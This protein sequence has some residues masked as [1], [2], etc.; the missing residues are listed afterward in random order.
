MAPVQSG[1]A[2]TVVVVD[3]AGRLAVTYLVFLSTAVNFGLHGF[4]SKMMNLI[5]VAVS[6]GGLSQAV[7]N[8]TVLGGRAFCLSPKAL[9]I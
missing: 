4:L 2:F 3:R 9:P 5:I 1:E 8:T 6:Y 7:I